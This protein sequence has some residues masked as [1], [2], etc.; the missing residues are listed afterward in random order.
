MKKD[1]FKTDVMFRIE[2][3]GQILAVFP[4]DI[5][6]HD[7]RCSCYAHIGQHSTMVWDYLKHTKP[8]KDEKEYIDLYRELT[9]I[10]YNLNVIKKRNYTKY[11][12]ALNKVR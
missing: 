4:Y 5:E 3:D 12:T 8:A 2:I 1:D 6:T 11:L 9:S 7:G 10:G